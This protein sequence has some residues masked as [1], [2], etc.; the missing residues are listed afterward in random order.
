MATVD[1][2]TLLSAAHHARDRSVDP[3]LVSR[4]GPHA[5]VN[6]GPPATLSGWLIPCEKI[7]PKPRPQPEI[8]RGEIWAARWPKRLK[9]TENQLIPPRNDSTGF[10]P[11]I[12][13][14]SVG[15]VNGCPILL[16]TIRGTRKHPIS[17]TK[18]DTTKH[19]DIPPTGYRCI[20]RV[21]VPNQLST[22][23]E[24]S[25]DVEPETTLGLAGLFVPR[26]RNIRATVSIIATVLRIAE[27]FTDVDVAFVTEPDT[28]KPRLTKLK[29]SVAKLE[30]GIF[31]SLAEL[32]HF[33]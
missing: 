29:D 6:L 24:S 27:F 13:Q 7:S 14:N 15:G 11:K 12:S 30:T 1:T 25:P 31:M 18:H 3:G 16:K 28:L 32:V 21:N 10:R 26:L 33:A 8:T 20:A 22:M 19:L 5:L 4:N 9:T 17:L 23:A 2:G